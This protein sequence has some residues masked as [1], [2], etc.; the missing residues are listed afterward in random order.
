MRQA[1]LGAG[2]ANE[3]MKCARGAQ[4]PGRLK[5]AGTGALGA[6]V[7]CSM[8]APP[9]S[10][11]WSALMTRGGAVASLHQIPPPIGA[12]QRGWP[13]GWTFAMPLVCLIVAIIPQ[14]AFAATTVARWHMNEK[15]GTVMH[16]SAGN[17]NGTL[18]AVRVG[19]PG[20]RGTAYAFNGSSSYV[21]VPSASDLDPGRA[22][23]TITIHLKTANRPQLHDWDLIRKGH[24]GNRRGEWKVE[25][26]RSGQVSCGFKGSRGPAVVEAGPSLDDKRWHTIRCV[27]TSS[28]IRLIVDGVTY[29]KAARVGS[30]TNLAPIEIGAWPG[31]EFF[32][33]SLDE[34][35]V[36]IG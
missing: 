8:V 7:I 25:Y 5:G 16:D 12:G 6:A 10:M 36:A 27:K 14:N 26:H 17:H 31:A 21:S 28:A 13:R 2:P 35:S 15:S 24:W 30:I 29:S 9:A 19:V 11:A 33:G 23:L 4:H 1:A 34:V 18:H 3:V 22:K 32:K 20:F